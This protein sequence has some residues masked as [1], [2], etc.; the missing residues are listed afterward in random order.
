[1]SAEGIFW[2]CA[3]AGLR[4][5]ARQSTILRIVGLENAALSCRDRALTRH[6]WRVWRIVPASDQAP[7]WIG[8]EPSH[9]FLTNSARASHS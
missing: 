6:P 7:V 9:K 2:G 8:V 3:Q 1:L 5:C 4:K